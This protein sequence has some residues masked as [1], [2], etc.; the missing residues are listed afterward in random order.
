[1]KVI[2]KKGRLKPPIDT[3]PVYCC[4]RN[5]SLR[6]P[7]FLAYYR[8]L[9]VSDFIFIDNASNDGTTEFLQKQD[10]CTVFWTDQPYSKSRCGIDWINQLLEE[11]DIRQWVLIVD[12]DEL[13][14]FPNIENLPLRVLIE[15]LETEG[16]NAFPTFL[17]D[18]YAA[19]PLNTVQ[20]S[21]G[22]AF[23][24]ACPYFDRSGYTFAKSGNFRGLPVR[25]GPRQRLFWNER[26]QTANPPV[27][28]KTPL[29]KW[30]PDMHLEASTHIVRGIRHGSSSGAL[31]H[32]KMLSDFSESIAVE[33]SRKEHWDQAGQYAAYWDVMKN[34]PDLSPMHSESEKY[35]SSMQ[36]V[37]LGLI[38]SGELLSQAGVK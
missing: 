7:Y 8:H 13:L 9:G 30:G 4:V 34:C 12:A 14:V 5:E 3:C 15:T 37:K 33:A 19:G 22:E 21:P 1:M 23:T 29:I 6:L 35:E 27:L 16:A 2:S 24:P 28:A 10:D 38:R 36:L 31:L 32:F 20:Y 17:L 11:F 25:G 18:M 26:T